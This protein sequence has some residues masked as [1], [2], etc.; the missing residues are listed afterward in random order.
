MQMILTTEQIVTILR[1]RKAG[2]MQKEICARTG[3]SKF[4]V[5]RELH[6]ANMPM[7]KRVVVPLA[8]EERI[9]ALLKRNCA[10]YKI[11]A[12]LGVSPYMVLKVM[13]GHNYKRKPGTTGA[14]YNL[15]IL[16]LRD[17]R[18]AIRQSERSIA[19]E[20]GV[21]REWL[22]RFRRD[23]W[24]NAGERHWKRRKRT[25]R[26]ADIHGAIAALFDDG[27]IPAGATAEILAN[28]TMLGIPALRNATPQARADFRKEL[29][30]ALREKL[31]ADEYANGWVN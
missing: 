31:S 24:S 10:Q 13:R 15:D 29:L 30:V 27:K 7:Y 3:L 9:V 14:K 20:F 17:I 23:M 22:S 21:S 28:A 16:T 1:L 6:R 5:S 11:A 26:M 19:S 8:A 18:R 4:L 2:L 12:T 25:P